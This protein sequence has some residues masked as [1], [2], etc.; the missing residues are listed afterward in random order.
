MKTVRTISDNPKDDAYADVITRETAYVA[1]A[2]KWTV[3]CSKQRTY[4]LRG[5]TVPKY[6]CHSCRSNHKCFC[7]FGICEGRIRQ[8]EILCASLRWQ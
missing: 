2:G 6:T 7:G 3:N 1:L 5:K 8:V 4:L